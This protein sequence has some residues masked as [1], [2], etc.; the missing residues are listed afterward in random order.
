LDMLEFIFIQ[1]LVDNY[2]LFI[3]VKFLWR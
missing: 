2:K 1:I 3:S